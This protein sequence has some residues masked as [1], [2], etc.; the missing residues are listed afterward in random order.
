MKIDR[1]DFIQKATFT[2][3]GSI[4]LSTSLK[5]EETYFYQT[6]DEKKIGYAIL[7]LRSF[8]SYVA[9]RISRSAK[10]RITALISSNHSKAKEWALKYQVPE[11]NIYTY[12]NLDE[13][14]NNPLID[15]VYIATP[16]GTH[17]DFAIK[18]FKAGKHVLTEKTMAATVAQVSTMIAAAETAKRKL[19]VAYQA[20]FEPFN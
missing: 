12:N 18:Y 8:A 17:A 2:T 1:R 16:V 14:S 7:G 3:V 11:K 9:P 20:R 4:A 15:A 5:A 6:Q 19:M 13:I 10:S